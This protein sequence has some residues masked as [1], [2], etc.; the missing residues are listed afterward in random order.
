MAN[1]RLQTTSLV[2]GI[3]GLV[4]QASY[5]TFVSGE[6]GAWLMLL[7]LAGL[8]MTS[9][10]FAMYGKAKGYPWGMGSLAILHALGLLILVMLPD[11][12]EEPPVLQNEDELDIL[13]ELKEDNGR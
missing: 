1:K 8:V 12:Y 9:V 11:Q 2:I 6:S 7:T 5:F 10:A 3:P 4:L 13:K